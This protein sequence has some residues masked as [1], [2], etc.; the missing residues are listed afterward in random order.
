MEAAVE[1]VPEAA[2]E[3]VPEAAV[4]AVPEAA[5]EA[6]LEAAVEAEVETTVET[7]ETVEPTVEEVDEAKRGVEGSSGVET[8]IGGAAETGEATA[9]ADSSFANVAGTC[10]RKISS[11]S[12][13]FSSSRRIR[14]APSS[15]R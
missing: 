11:K 12:L 5:V 1:A 9:P 3:A 10:P 7:A 13:P 4:K 2:A 15:G 6:V 8:A 14:V